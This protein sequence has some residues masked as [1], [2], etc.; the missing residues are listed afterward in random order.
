MKH[1]GYVHFERIKVK[2]LKEHVEF[3][4]LMMNFLQVSSDDFYLVKI[5][6]LFQHLNEAELLTRF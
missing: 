4:L 3:A 6:G 2:E 5:L 1:V